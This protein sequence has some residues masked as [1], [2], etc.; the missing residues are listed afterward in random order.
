MQMEQQPTFAQLYLHLDRI[1]HGGIQIDRD[2]NL[3]ENP[4][5]AQDHGTAE[6][7]E[8]TFFYP[9]RNIYI[10][11]KSFPTFEKLVTST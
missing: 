5:T 3:I 1:T 10:Q 6:T 7:G 9:P 2:G 4:H 11:Y 8:A